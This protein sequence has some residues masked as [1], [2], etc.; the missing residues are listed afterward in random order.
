M[1]ERMRRITAVQPDYDCDQAARATPDYSLIG[2]PNP[3]THNKDS[4]W[5]Y[6][7]SDMTI[8]RRLRLHYEHYQSMGYEP[9]TTGVISHTW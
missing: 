7:L 6:V 1:H 5:R 2:G 8:A 9:P 4:V 3:V